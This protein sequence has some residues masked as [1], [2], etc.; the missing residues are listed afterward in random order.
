M[1][2][3]WSSKIGADDESSENSEIAKN[4]DNTEI[5]KNGIKSS[6]KNR[7]WRNVQNTEIPW[8]KVP[9][10]DKKV[11]NPHSIRKCRNC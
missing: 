7:K 5:A 4:I 11:K 8:L 2:K 9:K 3:R 1:A 6:R 10:V